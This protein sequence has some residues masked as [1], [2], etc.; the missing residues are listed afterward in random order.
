MHGKLIIF[1]A[2]SGAGKSTLVSHV[3]GS[4]PQMAF[5]C[6]ATS[7]SPRGEEQEGREYYF[8]TPDQFR[9]KI[10]RD[11]FLEWEEVYPGQYYGTLK[12]D[13]E[14][15]QSEGKHV[16][17]DIDVVG[18]VNLKKQFGHEALALFIQPPDLKTLEQRLRNRGTDS[19][20]QI[21]KRIGKAEEEMQYAPEFD[22]III[23]DDL[24]IARKETLQLVNQFIKE[25]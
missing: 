22:H 21:A 19:E 25:S 24:D 4:I 11:E 8:V 5:S 17:F 16:V 10:S 1:S 15:L 23:N 12:S 20:E 13:V 9:E 14:R 18:G 7:R 3:M 2:P 6:S